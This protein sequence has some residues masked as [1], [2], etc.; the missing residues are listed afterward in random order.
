M[1]NLYSKL[2]TNFST[3]TQH[4][5]PKSTVIYKFWTPRVSTSCP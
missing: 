1:V 4:H 3:F 2:I 5:L